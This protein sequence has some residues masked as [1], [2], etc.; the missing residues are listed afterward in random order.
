MLC[1]QLEIRQCRFRYVDKA[2]NVCYVI[3]YI[4]Y[5]VIQYIAILNY[6]IYL[7]IVTPA[8]ARLIAGGVKSNNE[9]K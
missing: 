4:S 7:C 1:T 6:I 8:V 2:N 3:L 5:N 9:I